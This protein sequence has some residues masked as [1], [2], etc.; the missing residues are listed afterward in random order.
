MAISNCITTKICDQSIM[1]NIVDSCDNPMF[2]GIEQVA[3]IINKGDI[4]KVVTDGQ[5]HRIVTDIIMGQDGSGNQKYAFSVI[6]ARNNPY[7]GTST[8]VVVGD[9]KNTFTRTVSLFVPMDGAKVSKEILDPMANGKFVVIMQNQFVN[10][11]GDNEYQIYGIDK[12]LKVSEMTQ[13]KYENNDY[14]LITFTEEE[15]PNS[16]RWLKHE[17]YTDD[18][19]NIGVPMWQNDHYH[20]NAGF[21]VYPQDIHGGMIDPMSGDTE[22][23]YYGTTLTYDNTN[24]LILFEAYDPT[25][26]TMVT[27]HKAYTFTDTGDYICTLFEEGR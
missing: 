26:P 3:V 8:S 9:Y 10:D 5:N 27:V 15:V 23:T 22:T 24:Y 18:T 1:N 4:Q 14:W 6:N 20:F 25:Q 2:S 21:D 12:G 11:E 7:Q 17:E 19:M 16:G 13:T